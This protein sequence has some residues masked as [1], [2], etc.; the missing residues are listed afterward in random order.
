MGQAALSDP[1]LASWLY[2]IIRALE[3]ISE[4]SRRLSDD[5]KARYPDIPW[6]GNGCRWQRLSPELRTRDTASSLEDFAARFPAT[7]IIEQELGRSSE[8]AKIQFEVRAACCSAPISRTLAAGVLGLEPN[9]FPKNTPCRSAGALETPRTW[10]RFI[11][12]RRWQD[13]EVVP[14]ANEATAGWT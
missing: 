2:A 12:Q 10:T 7:A 3:I 4:A 5:L 1:Q 11:R 6:R 14:C 13:T 9:S 8:Q